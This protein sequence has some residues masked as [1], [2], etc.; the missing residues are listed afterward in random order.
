MQ[1]TWLQRAFF[2]GGWAGSLICCVFTGLASYNIG[3]IDGS[4]DQC[5]ILIPRKTASDVV[6]SIAYSF[7]NDNKRLELVKSRIANAQR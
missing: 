7:S 3:Y 4:D 6:L 1:R 2:V 5:P